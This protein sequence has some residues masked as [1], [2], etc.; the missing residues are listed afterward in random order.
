MRGFDNMPAKKGD[1]VTV[2]Y[3]GTLE[4]GTSFDTSV[5]KEPL[6][7]MIG[8]GQL[9]SGFENGI[10]GMEEGKEKEIIIP[11]GEGYDSG[12]LAGKKLIFKVKLIKIGF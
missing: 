10:I 6:Q 12:E 4:D 5:G 3:T 2:D 11:S 9:L 7:F 8:S 1:M